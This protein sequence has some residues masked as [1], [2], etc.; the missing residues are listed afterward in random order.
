MT[1]SNLTKKLMEHNELNADDIIVL[2]SK[3]LLI[4]SLKEP[5][6]EKN[7]YKYLIDVIYFSAIHD[8]NNFI[9]SNNK[10]IFDEP[11]NIKLGI[12]PPKTI[13]AIKKYLKKIRDIIGNNNQIEK[14]YFK[15]LMIAE[16]KIFKEIRNGI[17]CFDEYCD[18]NLIK[19]AIYETPDEFYYLLES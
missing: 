17:I 18:Y 12:Y 6:N 16:S 8:F 13:K 15:K 4:K 3:G 9:V 19:R 11:N 2:I 7:I 5:I 1:I 14:T 10:I